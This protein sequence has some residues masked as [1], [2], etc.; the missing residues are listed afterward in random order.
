MRSGEVLYLALVVV[1]FVA[2]SGAIAL[3][4]WRTRSINQNED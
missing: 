1:S 3:A 4:S 2:L